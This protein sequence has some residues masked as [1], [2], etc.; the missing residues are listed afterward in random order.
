MLLGEPG[1]GKTA[2]IHGLAQRLA[3]GDVPEGLVG[4]SLIS[5]ELG[6]LTAGVSYNTWCCMVYQGL[7]CLNA[8]TACLV[9]SGVMTV[10]MSRKGR[11]PAVGDRVLH[12]ILHTYSSGS[13]SSAANVAVKTAAL[14]WYPP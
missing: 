6:L 8:L 13:S 7:W 14:F 1:V 3:A 2:I 11:Q 10:V 5:L 12:R 9:V 4:A